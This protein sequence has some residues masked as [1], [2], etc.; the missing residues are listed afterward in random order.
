M[1]IN[2]L[3]VGNLKETYLKNGI[4]EYDKRLKSYAKINFVEVVE[5]NK[6][7]IDEQK[8]EEG[9]RLLKRLKEDS[10]LIAL[11]IQG[12]S[13]TSEGLALLIKEVTTY[14]S[15]SITFIIGGSNGLDQS[16]LDKADYLLSFSSFTFPHQ[17]MR[18]ILIEQIYRSMKINKNE[19]YHK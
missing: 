17:L 16:V 2:I 3:S 1:E 7:T 10:F 9:E 5:S 19:Q 13:I 4:N 11:A 14:K 12:K 15:S 18:L 8:K 6:G